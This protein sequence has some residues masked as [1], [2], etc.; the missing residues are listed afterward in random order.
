MYKLY[1]DTT[2]KFLC[3]GITSNDKIL[4]QYQ[5]V[6]EKKQSE[7]AIPYIEKALN[8]AKIELKDIGEVI[9]TIGP[10]SFTGIWRTTIYLTNLVFM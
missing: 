10:G 7:M 5:T 6:A 3:I 1:L 2:T 8:E 4:Y 9:V